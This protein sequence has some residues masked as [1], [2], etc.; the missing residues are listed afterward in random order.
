MFG[1]SGSSTLGHFL[2]ISSVSNCCIC[3]TVF[4]VLSYYLPP[5][6]IPQKLPTFNPDP[7]QSTH[8]LTHDARTE[9]LLS[10][11]AEMPKLVSSSSSATSCSSFRR[12]HAPRP[13]PSP[14]TP[15]LGRQCFASLPLRP[16]AQPRHGILNEPCLP[17]ATVPPSVSLPTT[18]FSPTRERRHLDG[19][20]GNPRNDDHK[21]PDKRVLK[22]GKSESS[23][24]LG[25]CYTE[26]TDRNIHSPSHPLA[27]PPDN[28]V[29]HPPS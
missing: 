29:Q 5:N 6:V 15:A 28:P 26:Q 14:I 12:L 24:V 21:P 25:F 1:S 4:V 11:R 2:L 13:H 9:G 19:L 10:G 23:L 16:L 7:L 3:C 8:G 27:S 17:P 20:D 18:Y 22:L